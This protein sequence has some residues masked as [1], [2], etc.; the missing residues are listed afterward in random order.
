LPGEFS[1]EVNPDELD[2]KNVFNRLYIHAKDLMIKKEVKKEISNYLS[3]MRA[4]ELATP[5]IN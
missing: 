3:M 4:K 1:D 2:I 5:K